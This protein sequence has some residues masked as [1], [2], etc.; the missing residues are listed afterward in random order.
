M[1]KRDIISEIQEKNSRLSKHNIYGDIELYTLEDSFQ[2]LSENDLSMLSLH[3]VGIA[4]CIE[5]SARQAIKQLID[6]NEAFLERAEGF[7]ENIKFDFLLT[8]ALSAGKITFGDLISHSLPVSNLEHIASHFETLFKKRDKATKFQTLLSEVR[9]HIEPSDEEI[10]GH[11]PIGSNQ[12]EAPLIIPDPKPLLSKISWIF[13][14]RHLVAHE[15][16]FHVVNLEE[17]AT[18]LSSARLFLWTLT[19]LVEQTLNPGESRSS[20]GIAIQALVKANEI[21][22][23][24][25]EV[26]TRILQ[27]I[28]DG[29]DST[30]AAFKKACQN[31]EDYVLAEQDFREELHGP[32]SSNAMRSLNADVTSQLYLH[33]ADYLK[34]VEDN[35]YCYTP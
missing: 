29:P 23:Q 16:N 7:K 8:R 21:Q 31:F 30:K 14:K 35:A 5:V 26:K 12:S 20:W 24:S 4:S 11:M 18:A 22:N 27:K 32:M 34:R 2:K 9:Q 25:E 19:E 1:A 28:S 33:R 15:A 6:S 17:V 3:M 13:E 10:F